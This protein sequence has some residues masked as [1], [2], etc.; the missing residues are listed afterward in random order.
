MAC[1]ISRAELHIVQQPNFGTLQNLHNVQLCSS[2]SGEHSRSSSS[3]SGLSFAAAA[4]AEFFYWLVRKAG[5]RTFVGLRPPSDHTRFSAQ[6]VK[7]ILFISKPLY[8]LQ[9]RPLVVESDYVQIP[10]QIVLHVN[11]NPVAWHC[12]CE[13]VTRFCSFKL[14]REPSTVDP[15]RKT[16]SASRPRV[17]KAL[18]CATC[19]QSC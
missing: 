11:V 12:H 4:A 6:R 3:Q 13:R 2:C 14:L 7:L 15:E 17:V 8:R 5:I 19:T 1:P 16:D 18:E 9:N 10:V